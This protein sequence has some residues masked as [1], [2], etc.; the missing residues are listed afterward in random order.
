[1]KRARGNPGGKSP[2]DRTVADEG[3]ELEARRAQRLHTREA[4]QGGRT[5]LQVIAVAEAAAGRA[6]KAV[7]DVTARYPPRPPLAC[8]E[9]C[10]WCCHKRV[11]TTAPEVLRIAAFLRQNLSAEAYQAVRERILRGDEQRRALKEDRWAAARL[12][13]PLLVQDRCSVYP[14]R[15]LTCRGYNS[16]AARACEQVVKVRGPVEVPVYAPQHRLATF[17][18]DGLRAGLAEA[19]LPGDLLELTAALRIAVTVPDAAERWLA[20]EPVFAPARLP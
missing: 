8:K 14:V 5:P 17:V 13:C 4:L 10:A 11:G 9:G 3:L 7:Q 6:D 18:L 2:A 20:G 16:S 12:P 15:P 1:M 19:G